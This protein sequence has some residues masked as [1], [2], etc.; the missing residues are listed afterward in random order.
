MELNH[1]GGQ[2]TIIPFP[3]FTCRML[4]QALAFGTVAWLCGAEAIFAAELAGVAFAG[5]VFWAVWAWGP[6]FMAING[7]DF[8]KYDK[9]WWFP[10]WWICK[11]CDF[12]VRCKPT[13]ALTEAQCRL[14]GT[15]YL[16]ARGAF[17]YPMFIALSFMTTR[18]AI[19]FG[20][21]CLLQGLIYRF[22]PTVLTAEYRFGAVIGAALA[23][24]LFIFMV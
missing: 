17:M 7:Q 23:V 6:G 5:L 24:T 20:W 8:R 11:L 16:T 18:Y 12:D 9:K 2:S 21:S 3:R 13:D 1:L 4:G 15:I 10:H 22:S 19:I 14:W